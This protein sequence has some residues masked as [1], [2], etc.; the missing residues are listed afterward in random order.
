[1]PQYTLAKSR[2]L[3]CREAELLRDKGVPAMVGIVLVGDLFCAHEPL[4]STS[5]LLR[6]A[7]QEDGERSWTLRCCSMYALHLIA[8]L[9]GKSGARAR[10]SNGREKDWW[11]AF[12]AIRSGF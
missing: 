7:L 3:P 2:R 4:V 10:D 8:L 12:F 6:S 9:L 5:S 11:T 1:M